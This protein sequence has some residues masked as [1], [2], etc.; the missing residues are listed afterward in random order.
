MQEAIIFS[1][2]SISKR[3][4]TRPIRATRQKLPIPVRPRCPSYL[5]L[6]CWGLVKSGRDK[7]DANGIDTE[8]DHLIPVG[9]LNWM[10]LES[11][12]DCDISHTLVSETVD[13][14]D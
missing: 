6:R 4:N 2:T 12:P 13:Y 11:S 9:R 5:R 3:Y 8:E 7:K 10:V 14:T 1:K